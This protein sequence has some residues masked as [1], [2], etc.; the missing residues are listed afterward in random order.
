MTRQSAP[1]ITQ[2]LQA[3]SGGDER[4]LERLTPL[5]YDELRQAAR[6]YMARQRHDHT[7]QTTALVNEVY[8]RLVK[9]REFAWQDRAHFFAVCAKLMRRILVDFARARRYQK[10]GGGVHRVSLD[11]ALVVSREAPDELLALDEV[12]TALTAVDPR[13]GQVVELRFFGGLSTKE[14]G[15][16]LGVSEG[17]VERDW[18]LAKLWM[19]RELR[20]EKRDG[21]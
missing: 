3:W 10:R 2:L 19:L 7:L 13:K 15:E 1:G 20:G 9:I 6:R 4:A 12:L 17:T 16:L 21:A 11:E 18:K 14:T 8:L 5:V